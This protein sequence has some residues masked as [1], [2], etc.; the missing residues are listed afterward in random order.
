MLFAGLSGMFMA[1]FLYRFFRGAVLG[2]M[3]LLAGTASLVCV[4][5]DADDD[6]DTPPVTVELNLAAP[7][8]KNLHIPKQHNHQ[9]A[10]PGEKLQTAMQ[11]S[12]PFAPTPLLDQASPQ[13]VV[14]LR[15]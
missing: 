6:D 9:A 15:T 11:A 12:L 3:L 2:V 10:V 13:M 5:Y 1:G 4:S 8:K 7:C 14:P